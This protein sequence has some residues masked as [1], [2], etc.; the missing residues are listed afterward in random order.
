MSRALP[1]LTVPGQHGR[2]R[3]R[4]THAGMTLIEIMIVL[5]IVAGLLVGGIVLFDQLSRAALKQQSMR[6]TGVIKYTYGQAAIYQRYHRLVIDLDSGEYWVESAG[7]DAPGG[8]PIIP[9][10]AL[11]GGPEQ[12]EP[13]P[14]KKR[15]GYDNDDTEGSV[16]GLTRPTFEPKEDF[17]L[18]RKKLDSNIKFESVFTPQSEQPITHGQ[19]SITFFPNGFVERSQIV[20]SDGGDGY[21]TLEIAPLTGRV[22]IESGKHPLPRDFFDTESDE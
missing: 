5:V 19:A 1:T 6:V 11:I 15:R 9:D 4:A 3:R 13:K 22:N 12:D 8:P 18:K 21:M 7:Q 14:S 20:L 2:I 17:I 10:A 16:F